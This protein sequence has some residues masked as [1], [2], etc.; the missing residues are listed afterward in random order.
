MERLLR[1]VVSSQYLRGDGRSIT[2]TRNL[3]E[4]RAITVRLYECKVQTKN[5]YEYSYKLRYIVHTV[6]YSYKPRA[7]G[8]QRTIYCTRTL[9]TS[10]QPTTGMGTSTRTR[11]VA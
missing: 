7:R 1:Y 9:T 2:R 3:L 10:K 5:Y 11:T 4:V 8:K 6:P